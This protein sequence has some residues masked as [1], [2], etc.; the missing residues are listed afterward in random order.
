M[1]KLSCLPLERKR[2]KREKQK[3]KKEKQKM[4]KCVS[5]REFTWVV[6]E[7]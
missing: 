3:M 7:K 2:M 1:K 5:E 4:E 6:E